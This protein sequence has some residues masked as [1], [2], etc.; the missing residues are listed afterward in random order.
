MFG[1]PVARVNTYQQPQRRVIVTLRFY[2][3]NSCPHF[4]A[5]VFFIRLWSIC[6]FIAVYIAILEGPASNLPLTSVS[7]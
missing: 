7:Q 5:V 1:A 4:P 2:P 6:I 3:L